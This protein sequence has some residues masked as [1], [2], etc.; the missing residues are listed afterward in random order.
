MRFREV[1][2]KITLFLAI[3]AL[4][5]ALFLFTYFNGIVFGCWSRVFLIPFLFK[6]FLLFILAK[7]FS[8]LSKLELG[9]K[10]GFFMD[11]FQVFGPKLLKLRFF[12]HLNLNI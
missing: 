10:T 6:I 8:R 4:F 2:I 9:Q 3:I 7:S 5:I 1:F 11:W 12:G